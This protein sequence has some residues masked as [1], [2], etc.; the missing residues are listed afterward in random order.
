MSN[1][2]NMAATAAG[3]IGSLAAASDILGRNREES[4][5]AR[6]EANGHILL[7]YAQCAVAI[8]SMMDAGEWTTGRQKAGVTS[9]SAALQEALIAE[10]KSQSVSAAKAKRLTEKAAAVISADHSAYIK[11]VSDAA[12]VN[13][14]EVVSKMFDAG[15]K[16]E[17][18]LMRHVSPPKDDAVLSLVNRV[19]K[20]S[21]DDRLRFAQQIAAYD[22]VDDIAEAAR[23]RIEAGDTPIPMEKPKPAPK[24]KAEKVAKPKVEKPKADPKARPVPKLKDAK[25]VAPKASKN[26]GDDDFPAF[27]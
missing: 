11:S 12:R 25:K 22:L 14:N 9:A 27:N 6:N 16:S 26:K 5:A 13:A 1:R 20:L 19:T 21:G 3:I 18:E 8:A 7:G 17:A 23:K 4:A 15:I 10:A 2:I 24:V